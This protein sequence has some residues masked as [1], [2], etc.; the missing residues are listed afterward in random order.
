MLTA[1]IVGQG[2]IILFM[3]VLGYGAF[4]IVRDAERNHNIR[5]NKRDLRNVAKQANNE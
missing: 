1:N 3:S 2:L 5:K 4:L